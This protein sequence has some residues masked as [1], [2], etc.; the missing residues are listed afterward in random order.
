MSEWLVR[1]QDLSADIE[2]TIR[3][4]IPTAALAV[5]QEL[6]LNLQD[7]LVGGTLNEMS[8]SEPNELA[9]LEVINRDETLLYILTVETCS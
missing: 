3:Q 2:F 7:Q 4:P 8:V 5:Y 6:K 1:L 9:C